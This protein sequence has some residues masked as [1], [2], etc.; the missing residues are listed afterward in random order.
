VVDGGLLRGLDETLGN[1]LRAIAPL[2][3]P[4]FFA[5]PLP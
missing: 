3:S 4:E 5:R 1:V 2:A